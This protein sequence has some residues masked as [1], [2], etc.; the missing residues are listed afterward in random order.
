V[1]PFRVTDVR[2]SRA[3]A[4]DRASG[5]LGHVSC[6]VNELRICL[7]LRRTLSGRHAIS[8]PRRRGHPLVSPLTPAATRSLEVQILAA[9]G[10]ENA[11]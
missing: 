2:F 8:L 7:T 6:V 10:L 1:T 5:L 4:A 11:P 3:A 9:L